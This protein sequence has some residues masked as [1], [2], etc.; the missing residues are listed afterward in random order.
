MADLAPPY[1]RYLRLLGFNAPP[2]GLEGLREV[3]QQHLVRVPFENISKLLLFKREGR[4]RVTTLDEFLEGIERLDLGGTCYT[5][6][7][8][9]ADL[10]RACGYDADLLGADMTNPDVHTSIRVRLAGKEYHVDV[11]FAGPFREPMRL[12][13]LPH[14]IRN[15]GFRYVLD[16]SGNGHEMSV[17]RGE[18]KVLRYFVHGPARGFDFFRNTIEE[19]YLPGKT[20]MAWLRLSR[21]FEDYSVDITDRTLTIHRNGLSRDIDLKNMREMR[22]AVSDEL[23]MP[24]CAVEEAIGVLERLNGKE[25]FE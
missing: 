6:N 22:A 21:F 25:F 15:G 5:C 12:D 8:Y 11:G 1:Q 17:W 7:P 14:E 3:V 2:Q 18:E 19:S 24:R 10:L 23:K 4:G 16:Q 9:L 13:H 20:F